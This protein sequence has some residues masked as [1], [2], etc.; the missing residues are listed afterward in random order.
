[1]NNLSAATVAA[2]VEIS[3]ANL[4]AFEATGSSAT[5]I[6]FAGLAQAVGLNPEKFVGVINGWMPTPKALANWRE[7]RLFTQGRNSLVPDA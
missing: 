6:N 4:T 1:M 3:E 2:K 5:K 7:L